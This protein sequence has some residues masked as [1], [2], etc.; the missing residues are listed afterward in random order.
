MLKDSDLPT[1][2]EDVSEDVIWFEWD[3][4]RYG[5]ALRVGTTA[6]VTALKKKEVDIAVATC[7][8]LG[9]QVMEA[10][11]K[12]CDVFQDIAVH[13]IE[14]RNKGGKSL[15]ALGLARPRV[16]VFD[17]SL[18][19]WV[20]ADQESVFVADRFDVCALASAI[21]RDD[22]AGEAVVDAEL[23]YLTQIR[24]SLLAFFE[25]KESID[26]SADFADEPATP[27]D[28]APPDEKARSFSAEFHQSPGSPNKA[29]TPRAVATAATAAPTD[30]DP[31]LKNSN[32]AEP[33][34][35]AATAK[36]RASDDGAPPSNGAPKKARVDADRAATDEPGRP[37]LGMPR[38]TGTPTN[39]DPSVG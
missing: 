24:E 26:W 6:L 33:G 4:V 38:I 21:A 36:R 19:A 27:R 8:L 31:V 35:R 3:G 39:A 34:G 10:I 14:S 37:S 22:D 28:A 7:N 13:V 32:G 30:D 18:N 25:P 9:N 5:I 16:V 12:R 1:D 15:S 11:G 20:P 29:E 17:D 2:V 23:G